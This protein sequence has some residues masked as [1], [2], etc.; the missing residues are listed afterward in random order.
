MKEQQSAEERRKAKH[1][2][3]NQSEKGQARNRKYEEK[4]RKGQVRWE[5]QRHNG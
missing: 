5:P 1:R 3:Y 4:H 2:K